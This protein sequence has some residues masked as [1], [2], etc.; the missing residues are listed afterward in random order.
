MTT[1][2]TGQRAP[3]P[4]QPSVSVNGTAPGAAGDECETCVSKGELALAVL[5][6]AIGLGIILMAIDLGAGGR[7]SRAIGLG[8]RGEDTADD[9]NSGP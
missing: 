4:P 1:P 2:G 7:L 9:G 8:Q 5:G 3:D 6:G